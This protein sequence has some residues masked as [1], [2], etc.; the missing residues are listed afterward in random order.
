MA[1]SVYPTHSTSFYKK[2]STLDKQWSA[3][4]MKILLPCS[5]SGFC[6]QCLAL[7]NNVLSGTHLT[8]AFSGMKIK[9]QG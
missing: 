8:G 1:F 6:L 7:I 5:H 4:F 2:V 3:K 9:A